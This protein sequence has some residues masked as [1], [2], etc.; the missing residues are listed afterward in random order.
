MFN[1]QVGYNPKTYPKGQPGYPKPTPAGAGCQDP[2][3]TGSTF[4]GT[5][6]AKFSPVSHVQQS[7]GIV[8]SQA[9]DGA[10]VDGNGALLA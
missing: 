10:A 7:R 8:A 5:G 4:S 3:L 6:T 2:V 9:C 1:G